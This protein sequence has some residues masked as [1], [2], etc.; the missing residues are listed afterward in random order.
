M[1]VFNFGLLYSIDV[2]LVYVKLFNLFVPDGKD[3]EHQVYFK[4]K[5]S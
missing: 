3:L 4:T 2:S 5:A 1:G